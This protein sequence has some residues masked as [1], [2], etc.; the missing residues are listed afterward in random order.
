MTATTDRKW[1]VEVTAERPIYLSMACDLF[2]STWRFQ[3]MDGR[4]YFEADALED[5]DDAAFVLER[6][7]RSL[8]AINGHQRSVHPNWRNLVV[9]GISRLMPD[10][11]PTQY[12]HP[13]GIES[14]SIVPEPTLYK[15][16]EPPPTPRDLAFLLEEDTDLA[17]VMRLFSEKPLDWSGMYK[18]FEI[19]RNAEKALLNGIVTKT[20]QGRFTHTASSPDAVGDQARHGKQ[21][22]SP[23]S[24]PMPIDEARQ[25]IARLVEAYEKKL[26]PPP[27]Y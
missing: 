14:A 24:N 17:K 13:L 1:R 25:M 9:Q 21:S 2:S 15:E 3:E 27:V 26:H 16:G 18:I 19:I 22:G 5:L 20:E 4:V 6:G 7:R 8:A 12:L 10:R 11:P 23:P